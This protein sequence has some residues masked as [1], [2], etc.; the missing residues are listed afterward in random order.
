MRACP[1]LYYT[2][3]YKYVI[4]DC[5]SLFDNLIAGIPSA[6]ARTPLKAPIVAF[7]NQNS[8]HFARTRT[9]RKQYVVFASIPATCKIPNI[10]RRCGTLAMRRSSLS[11]ESQR[12]A[13]SQSSTLDAKL[14]GSRGLRAFCAA[15]AKQAR[16]TSTG[17]GMRT[18]CSTHAAREPDRGTMTLFH[19]KEGPPSRGGQ[20]R[21]GEQECGRAVERAA[22][23]ESAALLLCCSTALT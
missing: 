10:P 12:V 13:N 18:A 20:N 16:K 9:Q 2:N 17:L 6:T 23:I 7:I 3:V 21:T 15:S 1:R 5:H 4:L 22:Y 19:A 8:A 14:A 11:L